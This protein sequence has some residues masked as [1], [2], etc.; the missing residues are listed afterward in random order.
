MGRRAA[1]GAARVFGR[2]ASRGAGAEARQ[3]A[4][5]NAALAAAGLKGLKGLNEALAAANAAR[6][7]REVS[8]DALKPLDKFAPRHNSIRPHEIDEMLKTCGFDSLDALV[9]ATVPDSIRRTDGMDLGKKAYTEGMSESQFI[10][11]FKKMAEKNVVAKNFVGMGYHGTHTPAV[12]LRNLLENPGWYTQY[13]PYQAEISQGRLESLL[14]FQSMVTDLTGMQL[15]NASLLDEATAAAEAMTMCSAIARG[16]K[17]KFLVSELC[18]P[19]TI[20]VCQSRAK[21]LGLE[22]V[23]GDHNSWD[24]TAK[25]VCGVLVQYPATDGAVLTYDDVVAKAHDNKI[26]V[27]AATDLLSLT[28]LKP[29]GEW[30][31]DIV[32]GSAQRFG[33]PMGYGGPHA[34]FL[35][36]SEEHKRLMPG[37]II[38]VSRDATGKVALR[39]AMQTREQ[40]I[41]RDKATS[42]ICT[43]QALLAN[44]A[45]MYG[46]YHGPDGL[47]NIAKRVNTFAHVFAAGVAK[48]GHTVPA[49]P[50][51]DTVKVNVGAGKAAAV[52]ETAKA[53]G[54]NI[55][56]LD[57]DNVTCAFDETHCAHDLDALFAVFNGGAPA[58][59]TAEGLCE[60]VEPG[61]SGALKR[62]TAFMQEPIFNDIKTEHEMLRYLKR[63]ENRDLSMVHSMIPLG[64][65]T[66][67]LNA[68]SEMLPI[69]WGELA[70]IH[71]F[72]PLDQTQGYQEMFKDLAAQLCSIT[73]FDAMSL[74]PNSGASGEYAGLMSIRAYH[75]SRGDG[76]RNICIIPVSAHGTNPATAVMT[77]YKIVPVGVDAKGNV[78]IEE[79]R[80]KAEQ[81]KDH[82]AALMITYPSTH[83]VYEDGIDTICDIIHEHGGQVYMDGANM[84]AQVGLTSPGHIGADVCHLNLHKTFCI[85]HGGGGPG[86]GPIGVKAHLAPFLPTHPVIPTGAYPDFKGDDKSFGAMAA[87]PYGS[88]LILPISYAYISMMGSKGLEM[89]SKQAILNAN[90]MMNRLGKHYNVVF[91]GKNGTCAHEFIIDIRPFEESTGVGAEDIAK[92][93][94]DYG[95]HAPT[96]SW[97]VPGTLMIEP[98]ESESKAELDR[99]CDAMI[100]I[101][102][103]I[104]EIAQGRYSPDNNVLVNSPHPAD[105][106]L[107]DA[108]DKPYPREK[109]AYPAPWTRIAKFWPTTKRVDNVWGDRNLI[110]KHKAIPKDMEVA[111]MDAMAVAS[112]SS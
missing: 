71:P 73:G 45:G 43:A 51:F 32:I 16:K 70:N 4:T 57:A 94:I 82:L 72:A 110:A 7:I 34:A 84:N 39:M 11:M 5:L 79:L 74:Q 105:E 15:S 83:G 28:M 38:G 55:R 50:F 35:A 3:V 48:L 89:A 81:H 13:T 23:V 66:M 1:L 42:N 88:S 14:N 103:E 77:G 12:V 49:Q 112:G 37:R 102:A 31:A 58:P 27:C 2:T 46:V 95:F 68:T 52:A 64:S 30:G 85:P 61:F 60:G 90:Y 6:G 98:T 97:P 91:T 21:G 36:C 29:P 75:E 99:F 9:D 40:H 101:R 24:L 93:L 25:D 10:T 107:S 17:P 106:V 26:L 108:W 41:R 53:A 54:I 33:V 96:M 92:R 47:R 100:S 109:A 104:E 44:I 8:T 20:A 63:L 87:A 22:C 78:N 67:K 111:A 56:V 59:F 86:M 80:K 19:Q 18:H 65:C 76:H 62:E 69:T